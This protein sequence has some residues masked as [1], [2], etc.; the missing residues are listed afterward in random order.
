MKKVLNSFFKKSDNF[1]TCGIGAYLMMILVDLLT[2]TSKDL[3]LTLS[4]ISLLKLGVFFVSVPLLIFVPKKISSLSIHRINIIV[5]SL[6]LLV[7]I[8]KSIS[9]FL[10]LGFI[11]LSLL[12]FTGAFLRNE[13][14]SYLYLFVIL[15]T[16]PR[17][18]TLASINLQDTALGFHAINLAETRF[19]TILWPVLLAFF[20]SAIFLIL[21]NNLPIEKYI[22]K[23]KK[24]FNYSVLSFVILYVVYLSIVVVYKVKT[25]DG[26]TFDIGIFS[27]MFHRMSTDLTAITTLERD[28][29][30][31]HFAVHISPIFYLMLPFYKVFPHVETLEVLQIWV[32]FSAV[33]PLRLLLKRL[34]FSK[35]INSLI[36]AWFVL[37]PVMTTAGGYHLHENCFLVPL[38]IWL[39]YFISSEQKWKILLVTLLL[40]FVKE[41]AF[42]YVVSIGLYFLFQ[43][44]F[45]LSSKTKKWIILAD[46]ILPVLYFALGLYLL[47]TYG[48]GGMVSR[49]EPYLLEGENGI[50]SV[51]KNLILHPTYV[52][53]KLLIA[54]KLGYLFFV[55][56]PL[57]FLPLVQRTWSN[58]L[59]S[60]PLIVINLLP[61]WPYQ[62]DIGFQYSYGS[63]TLLFIMA[64][65]ALEDLKEHKFIKEKTTL[66]MVTVGIIMSGTLLHHFTHN[67]SF[68]I[69]YYFEHKEKFDTMRYTLESLPEEA[70][71]VTEGGY[72][73]ALRNHQYLYDIFYHNDKKADDSIDYIVIP[74]EQKGNNKVYDPIIE[75]YES[76]G[77]K[78]SKYA[79]KE[80]FI[81]EKP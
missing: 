49:F 50:L 5:S 51:L 79:T 23:Y 61:D 77:Y 31:S 55:L 15:L 68:N 52:F 32:V 7:A 20:L 63:Q 69:G 22:E 39:F 44:R 36:I 28:R 81:L 21:F 14:Y 48:E 12:L 43:K 65:L 45:S 53:S 10:A 6:I 11:F 4:P 76:L 78:E 70:S 27:Q 34:N 38:I 46:F 71:V 58:Y 35:S 24:I 54:R 16:T 26:S 73:P 33:I 37:I 13:K 19:N 17:L 30:L 8:F 1:L 67:W 64:L 56:A 62:Y 57:V 60:L 80:L 18:L 66:A 47:N 59:L 29:V 40:L 74:R 72:T 42:I 41:D 9:F 3:F 75:S 2:S 25:F